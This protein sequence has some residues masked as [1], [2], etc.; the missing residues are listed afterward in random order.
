MLPLDHTAAGLTNHSAGMPPAA[1][2][3]WQ[4]WHEGV[5]IALGVPLFFVLAGHWELSE[6]FVSWAHR[7]EHFQVDEI[8]LTLLVLSV[9]LAV[10]AY[11]RWAE[12]GQEVSAR[13]Q[14]EALA[15]EMLAQNRLLA[16][17]LIT[18]QE[19]ERHHLARELHDEIGQSCVAIK[20]DAATIAQ[21]TQ[22][23]PP[24]EAARLGRLWSS[25][26]ASALAIG[27]TADHLQAVIRGLLAELRPVALDELGLV[28]ALGMLTTT[29]ASRHQLP[30]TLNVQGESTA[31]EHLG[32]AVNIALFRI[33]QESLTN[34]VRHAQAQTVR[35]NL[36]LH[37]QGASSNWVVLQVAD[38]GLGVTYTRAQTT[39]HGMGLLGI[40]ERARALG[41]EAFV[42]GPDEG[43][44]VMEVRLPCANQAEELGS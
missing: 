6:R 14:A 19:Q 5:L 8:P 12:L 38:D 15:L 21:D 36:H 40:H 32:E 34:V 22:Q 25:C 31:F 30:C 20:V 27:E 39:R 3:R 7:Y 23:P 26:H 28:A 41:G 33:V 17:R 13:R 9:A 35:V 29:W 1:P 42:I 37:S 43:G 16:H 2:R 11:R 24:N 18:L 10:F 4:A 44:T